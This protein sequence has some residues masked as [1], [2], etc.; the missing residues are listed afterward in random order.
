MN[1]IVTLGNTGRIVNTGW[2]GRTRTHIPSVIHG[3]MSFELSCI[4][5]VFHD[6]IIQT[7]TAECT[8]FPVLR[9]CY[10]LMRLPEAGLNH[11]PR[12]KRGALR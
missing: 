8:T 5:V 11:C 2:H 3:V 12:L 9:L 1:V 4:S 10:A 6:L 7:P